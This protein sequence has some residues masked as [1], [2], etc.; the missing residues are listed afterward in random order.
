MQTVLPHVSSV[1]KKGVCRVPCRELS[2][3]YPPG[4]LGSM[5]DFYPHVIVK[6]P[7]LQSLVS[8]MAVWGPAS[9]PGR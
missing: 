4:P 8:I 3:H 1:G 9:G 2:E 6:T 7:G 5:F